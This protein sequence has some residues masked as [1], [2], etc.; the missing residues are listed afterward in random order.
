MYHKYFLQTFL[1]IFL[2]AIGLNYSAFSQDTIRYYQDNKLIEEVYF[3]EKDQAPTSAF[4]PR[5]AFGL[6]SLSPAVYPNRL[7]ASRFWSIGGQY[8][9]LILQKQ[10]ISL[11]LGLEIAW[12]N[13]SWQTDKFLTKNQDSISFVS[14]NAEQIHKNKLG[15]LNLS[16]P[17]IL[18]KSFEKNWRIGIG[19]YADWRLQSF[20]R[21]AY[22]LNG[23]AID[24]KNF[25]DFYLQTLRYGLQVE[26]KYKFI[27]FFSKYDL[28]SLFKNEK[29]Q[30]TAIWVFGI[31]F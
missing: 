15:I 20:S 13:L 30:K 8:R 2:I 26:V 27:R 28:N 11:G 31:G 18:Y 7:F 5:I 16:L 24:T 1:Q 17:V 19:T 29:A 3:G 23:E 25:S 12:N 14:N 22:T 10:G 21:T 9:R 4:V 6:Q